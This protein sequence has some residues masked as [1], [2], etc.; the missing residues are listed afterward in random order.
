MDFYG[1]FVKSKTNENSHR[2]VNLHIKYDLMQAMIS[3]LDC[4]KPHLFQD[5]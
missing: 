5:V 4:M 3:R 1:S 2:L